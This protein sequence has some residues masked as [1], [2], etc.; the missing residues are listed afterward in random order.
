M[1]AKNKATVQK[2]IYNVFSKVLVGFKL[3]SV[4]LYLGEHT[5]IVMHITPIPPLITELHIN[6]KTPGLNPELS[7]VTGEVALKVEKEL[8]QIFVGLPVSSISWSSGIFNTVVNYL[9]GR[10]LPG[11]TSTFSIQEGTTT[12]LNLT[13][14]PEEM[15]V[16]HV[17]IDYETT[18]IP[19]WLVKA[20]AKHYQD[21]AD[22]LRGL[23]VEFL[24]HYRVRLEKYL[25]ETINDFSELQKLGMTTQLSIVPGEET[26]VV[27]HVASKCVQAKMEGRYFL[28]HEENFSNLQAFL[29]Y[30][31]GNFQ[32]Y[33]KYFWGDNPSGNWKVGCA[34]PIDENFSGGFEYEFKHLYRQLWLHYHFE[35]GDYLDMKLGLDGS[36]NEATIGIYLNRYT[37]LEVVNYRKDFGLQLMFHF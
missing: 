3:E 19:V 12:E 31:L 7:Q 27:L 25:T 5:K 30:N 20:A 15:V 4:D 35:R 9:L 29:G 21:K 16:T 11:F 8:N 34:I 17:T 32:V 18:D 2:V 37:N 26:Q 33:S 13:L 6:L 22:L 1:L 28:G 10:E 36:P 24:I 23:P 14:I